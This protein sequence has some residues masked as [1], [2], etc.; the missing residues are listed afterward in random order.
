MDICRGW[1]FSCST[2]IHLPH[3]S[4]IPGPP[5][6]VHV[7]DLSMGDMTVEWA[8]PIIGSDVTG[9]NI[10]VSPSILKYYLFGGQSNIF[11]RCF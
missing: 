9:Y 2:S 5:L 1:G 8:Q 6:R 4:G 11:Y 7:T 3:S 10:K